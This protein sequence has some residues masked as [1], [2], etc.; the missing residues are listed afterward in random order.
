M[1]ASE[2]YAHPEMLVGT[3]WLAKH[4]HDP[5][6]RVVDMGPFEGYARAHIPGAV[7]PGPA[8]RSHY[9]KDP[10]NP[11]H[12][13]PPEAFAKV[14][15]T[16]GIGD[17][18][19]VVAYDA[20]GGHTAARLWWVMDY[21]GN[22]SCKVVNGGW[23]KWVA[24]GHSVAIATPSYPPAAYTAK[25]RA[26]LCKLDHMLDH[27]VD[28]NAVIID[29]RSDG[30]WA[31]TEARGNK[32]S[33]HIPSAIH[34]EWKSYVTADDLKMLKPAAELRALFEGSGITPEKLAITY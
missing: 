21:Y 15:S 2:G 20:D 22:G 8:D 4:L 25:P 33:G 14:M 32:R 6:L 12:V 16:L 7:H 9:F 34:L 26:G 1:S 18:T 10:E 27:V 5:N 3:D 19:T 29:V 11:A 17:D 30:E 31:G 28:N 24:T 23:N 13:M